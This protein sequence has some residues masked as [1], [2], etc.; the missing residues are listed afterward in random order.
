MSRATAGQRH[1]WLS[2]AGRYGARR[3]DGGSD[4]GSVVVRTGCGSEQRRLRRGLRAKA[5][6][7]RG[8]EI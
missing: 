4:Q 2:R 6:A 5:K 3:D 8:K 7:G 1:W